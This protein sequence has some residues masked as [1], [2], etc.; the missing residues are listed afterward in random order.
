MNLPNSSAAT[1]A[2]CTTREQRVRITPRLQRRPVFYAAIVFSY[3][4]RHTVPRGH[5]A[6]HSRPQQGRIFRHGEGEHGV[7]RDA[8][9]AEG[10]LPGDPGRR[11]AYD[12]GFVAH[13][14]FLALR[15]IRAN[16][17]IDNFA[18]FSDGCP[19]QFKNKDSFGANGEV[20]LSSPG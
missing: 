2:S 6:P 8:P 13:V 4:I 20:L 16:T 11:Q 17:K 14:V 18:V 9:E 3:G 7:P 10:P 12:K 1:S 15:W 5:D 19:A